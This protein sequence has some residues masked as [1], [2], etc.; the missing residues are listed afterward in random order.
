MSGTG[1]ALRG[2]HAAL[3]EG[4]SELRARRDELS[5]R[6]RDEEAERGRLQARIAI[7]SRR[8]SETS[9]SLAGLRSKFSFQMCF[10]IS[11]RSTKADPRMLQIRVGVYK[12]TPFILS[13]AIL[14]H[15]PGGDPSADAPALGTALTL[16][17]LEAARNNPPL[18]LLQTPSQ[19]Q[20]CSVNSI[21]MELA[22]EFHNVSVKP[23]LETCQG[24]TMNLQW[25]SKLIPNVSNHSHAVNP[26]NC[27]VLQLQSTSPLGRRV[28]RAVQTLHSA[29][30]QTSTEK[31]QHPPR[32]SRCPSHTCLTGS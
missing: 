22:H 26:P 19:V 1:A 20:G 10:G 15:I 12:N 29:W 27:S 5:G 3:R 7:L 2:H 8:L 23:E 24:Q 6:I 28:A 13:T 32:D 30:T 14:R 18:L 25:F 9:E 16:L 17:C 31:N 11:Q 21:S 4:L